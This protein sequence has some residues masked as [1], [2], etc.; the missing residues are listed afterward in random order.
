MPA[1]S[2]VVLKIPPNPVIVC[3]VFT[4][5]RQVILQSKTEFLGWRFFHQSTPQHKN[6]SVIVLHAISLEPGM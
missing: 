2:A 1:V 3:S 4:K 6:V 5:I